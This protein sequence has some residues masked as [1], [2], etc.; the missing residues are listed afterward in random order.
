MQTIDPKA[1]LFDN[2]RDMDRALVSPE[3][4]QLLDSIREEGVLQPVLIFQR[5]EDWIVKD[6]HRR[7]VAARQAGLAEIPVVKVNPPAESTLLL[8]QM[9]LNITQQAL[10]PIEQAKAFALLVDKHGVAQKAIAASLGTTD[11][12]VS[13]F[14]SL[15]K[16]PLH[17]QSRVESG[18]LAYTAGYRLSTLPQ[19]ALGV[20]DT[21]G[22]KTVKHVNRYKA[23]L[24]ATQEVQMDVVAGFELEEEVP[25]EHAVMVFSLMQMAAD[26][27]K[28]ALG[29][30][31]EHGISVDSQKDLLRKAMGE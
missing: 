10:N 30:A 4:T 29:L 25:D 24:K 2:I 23:Q 27:L 19:S 28:R 22:I 6:G 31:E 11:G 18:H 13:Q 16:L 21:K 9:I 8:H 12:Y 14:L 26:M 20:D 1:L 15:L 7:V 5:G 3:F 17:L